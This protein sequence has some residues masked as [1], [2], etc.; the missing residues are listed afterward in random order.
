MERHEI[1]TFLTLTEELHF[2]RTAERLRV[3][4]ARVSQS[5]KKLERRIGAP[6][7]ERTTRMVTMTPLGRQLRDD[8]APA[9]QRIREGISRAIATARGIAGTLRVGFLTPVAGELILAVGNDFRAQHPEC[10]I[11]IRES[12]IA[13][14]CAPLRV[15][16]VDLLI[17]QLPVTEPGLTQGPVVIREPWVL[18]VPARHP[19]ARRKS[20]SIEDLARDKIFRPAGTPP[21]QWE[22][23]YLPWQTP[24]GRPIERGAAVT[25][26]QELLTMIAAG[27]GICP[28]GEH[29][30][31]Y[32]ARPDIVYVPFHDAPE[33]EFGLVWRTAG[34]TSRVRA[35]T[36]AVLEHLSQR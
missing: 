16:E 14:P 4:Q 5:I 36:D 6:L 19:F 20:V 18:A 15:G 30:L 25:T 12:T 26:F 10:E 23:S 28:V 17:S 22:E 9:Q 33:L 24:T 1:E 35:F 7:F 27:K 8:L 34:Q 13:D 31:R 11:E 29:N 32:H 3:S 2:G 21:R